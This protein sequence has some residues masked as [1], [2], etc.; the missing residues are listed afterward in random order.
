MT[1][2]RRH[3]DF[4]GRPAILVT[5][6]GSF[7]VLS[8]S[9][10]FSEA[11]V[12]AR[13]RPSNGL[14]TGD[15]GGRSE[16][17]LNVV[18]HWRFQK[19][20]AGSGASSSHLIEDSSGNNHHGRAVG[21][22]RFQSVE[23]PSANLA[24]AFDGHDDRIAVADARD[25]QLTKSFTIEAWVD[26]AFYPESSSKLSHIA[27]RGDNRLGFDPWF[28][29]VT[30]SGQLRFLIANGQNKASVVLSP[31]P[32]PTRKLIHVAAVLDDE[33]GTQSLF[34]DGA[35]VAT[36]KTKIRA[37]GP[38]GGTG[39]GIGIGGRQAHS[40]QGFRGSIGE[41]RISARALTESQFLPLES[42]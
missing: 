40:N 19:G 36:T 4:W 41:V 17:D 3:M 37:C 8:S 23:L 13:K 7:C 6:V 1:L 9:V 25:F 33:L 35:R 24:L 27:F 26:V 21:G 5:L 34:I 18:A 11:T 15:S 29:A 10:A 30:E 32:L 22:P 20:I 12:D 28:L 2:N 16:R 38:L 31:E 14:P 39:P 42:E